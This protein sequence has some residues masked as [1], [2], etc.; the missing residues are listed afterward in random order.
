MVDIPLGTSDWKR[1]VAD[2]PDVAIL[3]RYY[4]QNPT[5]L[6]TQVALLSRPSLKRYL[7]V[8]AG[9]IRS[10][11]SQPGSFEDALFVVSYDEIYRVD[12]D[13]TVTFI[14]NGLAGASLKSSPSMAATA[15]LG[16]T[17]EYLYIADG[18]VLWV[19]TEDGF[20]FGELTA[21][22][23]IASTDEVKIGDIYYKWTSGS[24]DA[25]TPD[26]TVTNPWLVA[27]GVDNA[28]S[29]DNLRVAIIAGLGQGTAYSTVL[30]ANPDIV[31]TS[32]SSLHLEIR[33]IL[34]GAGGNGLTTTVI[35]GSTV[36]WGSGTLLHGGEPSFTQVIV[37]DD[38]GVVSVG[39]VAGFIIVV[40][41]QGFG[42][43]GRFYWI[44][45]GEVTIDP[46]NFATAERSPDPVISVR[47]VGD[48]FWL[49]GT[50]STEVWYPTG[51]STGITPFARV[52]GRLFDSGVWGGTDIAIRDTV[53]LVDN[54]GV[55][56]AITGAG[57]KRISN[58]SIEERMREGIRLAS[59][60]II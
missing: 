9:P 3:N 4:E 34:P 56:Y 14:A 24:V 42:V 31:S 53:V 16:G 38:V 54:D 45:P 33:A 20:A 49:L 59:T 44:N 17:P 52:Q 28:T 27:V 2:E 23:T 8:G 1:S 36:S 6:S 18:K 48:Q 60:D 11:Y 22:S 15:K 13:E 47:V 26:G 40:T 43:N 50:N 25:G 46:L 37:P 39:Y 51:D 19:Y 10:I 35:S 58:S 55:V 41:A 57:P 29:L 21:S 5:N 32:S 30:A 12:Q 7:S